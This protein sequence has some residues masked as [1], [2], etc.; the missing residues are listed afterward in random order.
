MTTLIVLF[1]VVLTASS[2]GAWWF[3]RD[4]GYDKEL[5]MLGGMLSGPL[6]MLAAL[7]AHKYA[8]EDE[9]EYSDADGDKNS[10]VDSNAAQ[11]AVS[12]SSSVLDIAAP[13]LPGT[14][15]SLA[16]SLG[17]LDS[18]IIVPEIDSR[19][20]LDAPPIPDTLP[21][22]L[23]QPPLPQKG[24]GPPVPPLPGSD[25]AQ[26]KI[27]TPLAG[28][29][30][31]INRSL[32]PGLPQ[33]PDAPAIPDQL[34]TPVQDEPQ[35]DQHKDS[36][37]P[38]IGANDF[39]VQEVAPRPRS[40]VELVTAEP[41]ATARR[42][43][44]PQEVDEEPK[45][46]KKFS[47]AKVILGNPDEHGVPTIAIAPGEITGESCP[48]CGEESWSDWYGLCVECMQPFP[49]RTAWVDP[50]ALEDVAKSLAGELQIDGETESADSSSGKIDL[51]GLKK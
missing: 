16:P 24:S 44:D 5:F 43:T 38:V 6:A 49:V 14:P 18:G 32:A 51:P 48:H 34:P 39:P 25:L 19:L 17:S 35:D 45:K 27:I 20:S 22:A 40:L 41:V 26:P 42:G 2:F 7:S 3:A 47:S 1:V 33:N 9:S 15:V 10:S 21:S 13:P 23:Q 31:A 8:V 4:R 30:P 36:S 37:V 12:S 29:A 46:R 11:G 28:N 50:K